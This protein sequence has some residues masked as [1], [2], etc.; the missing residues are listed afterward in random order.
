[1]HQRGFVTL[2]EKGRPPVTAE[3]LFQLFPRDP[4]ED[5]GVGNLVAIEVEDREHRAVGGRI[6]KLVGMPRGGQR[7]G[8]RLAIPDDAGDDEIG[9]VE[10]RPERMAERIAELAALVDRAGALRRSVAGNASGK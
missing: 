5:G 6:E 3:Q 10:R 4:S 9:I 1:M 8:F 2:D 7:S